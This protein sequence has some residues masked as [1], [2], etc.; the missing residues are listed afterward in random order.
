L[1]DGTSL[2]NDLEKYMVTKM[3]QECGCSYTSKL[4]TMFRDLEV[5]SYESVDFSKNIKTHAISSNRK[6]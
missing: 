1:I 2:S 4:E 3:K 5:S 6:F